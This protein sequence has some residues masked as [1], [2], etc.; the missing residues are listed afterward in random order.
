MEKGTKAK[1][2]SAFEKLLETK[3][4]ENITIQNIVEA[5]GVSKATFYRHFK[6]KYAVAEWECAKG[7]EFFSSYCPNNYAQIQ[8]MNRNYLEYIYS[9]RN[10][11]SAISKIEG[12]NSFIEISSTHT[13]NIFLNIYEKKNRKIPEEIK[14]ITKFYCYGV[15]VIMQN[16]IV[17]GFRES[18]EYMSGIT[19]DC[20]P[21]ILKKY[22]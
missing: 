10:F 12:Q 8:I 22:L 3:S 18:P 11:Y 1:I 4:F 9:K 16:W 17:H 14:V 6:D 7:V 2:T 20:V 21:E 19:L 13:E 15:A 5:S